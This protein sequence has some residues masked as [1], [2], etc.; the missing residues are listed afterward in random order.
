MQSIA[1]HRMWV[2]PSEAAKMLSFR[3]RLSCWAGVEMHVRAGLSIA[4]VLL[5]PCASAASKMTADLS[6]EEKLIVTGMATIQTDRGAF[7]LAEAARAGGLEIAARGVTGFVLREERLAVSE[8]H[9]VDPQ[10]ANRSFGPLDTA[11]VII[12]TC[13][14]PCY[15]LLYA[16]Q[17]GRLSM[18]GRMGGPVRWTLD[19]RSYHSLKLHSEPD[20]FF[21]PV[22][23]G[24]MQFT[25]GL[26]DEE[27]AGLRAEEMRADGLVHLFA[28]N[29]TGRIL[30]SDEVFT[31]DTRA[32]LEKGPIPGVGDRVSYS[33]LRVDLQLDGWTAPLDRPI[34]FFGDV[35]GDLR[36]QVTTESASGTVRSGGRE[37]TLQKEAFGAGGAFALTPTVEDNTAFRAQE[38][39]ILPAFTLRTQMS[40]DAEYVLVSSTP[41]HPR[42]TGVDA[43]AKIGL[44]VILVAIL[45]KAALLLYS[46]IGTA[47]VLASPRRVAICEVIA[48][49]PGLTA[50]GIARALGIPR[51]PVLHHLAILEAHR[52]VVARRVGWSREYYPPERVPTIANLAVRAALSSGTGSRVALHVQMA[53][54]RA[55]QSSVMTALG[56]SQRVTSY[57]LERLCDAGLVKTTGDRPRTYRPTPMLA[58]ALSAAS[59]RAETAQRA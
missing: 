20:S 2:V 37:H 39:A 10:K 8:V 17:D 45:A 18:S 55:T 12:E 19:A 35:S 11:R 27:A 46:R 49:R 41:V 56:L 22:A 3:R 23:S 42:A 25:N 14:D 5:V 26:G 47:R 43:A 52:L 59:E 48:E 36:G 24:T 9:F 57:H 4:L 51:A 31:F 54:G 34:L 53:A 15:L 38:T 58:E 50:V 13:V 30:T 32:R 1:R 28:T 29:V 7:D 33:F 6:F 21:Y 40:G 16:D 44:G